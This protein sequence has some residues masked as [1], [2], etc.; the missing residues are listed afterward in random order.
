MDRSSHPIGPV[1]PPSDLWSD[2]PPLESYRHLKQLI[3]LLTCLER[4]WHDRANFFVGGN[5]SLYYSTQQPHPKEVPGPDFFVVLDTERRERKSW[6][7]WEENGKYP[8]F[9]LELLSERTACLDR[10]TKKHLYQDVFR[11]PDYVWFDPYSLELKGFK[12]GYRYYEEI[13][14]TDEGWIWSEELQLYLGIVNQQLRFFTSVGELVLT[15]EEAES[16]ERQRAEAEGH[17]AAQAEEQL[18]FERRQ[19]ERL[20]RFAKYIR[21]T[22]AQAPRGNSKSASANQ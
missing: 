11:T 4:L 15:P 5:M 20:N 6:V 18:A 8:N 17:R 2:E 1:F 21:D 10:E 19:M 16:A 14:P 22:P 13:E 12:R 7:V 3:L 9:I